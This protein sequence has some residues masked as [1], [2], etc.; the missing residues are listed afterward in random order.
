MEAQIWLELAT[1]GLSSNVLESYLW[2]FSLAWSGQT[3]LPPG[4]PPPQFEP[5]FGNREFRFFRSPKGTVLRRESHRTSTYDK[6]KHKG[7]HIYQKLLVRS[8]RFA[9][10]LGQDKTQVCDCQLVYRVPVIC[11]CILFCILTP[12]YDCLALRGRRRLFSYTRLTIQ[13]H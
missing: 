1:F 8:S 11:S 6:V 2:F 7:S 9:W 4:L 10:F 13:P 12:N 3:I 5:D